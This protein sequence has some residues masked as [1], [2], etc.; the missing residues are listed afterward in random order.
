[1]RLLL[2]IIVFTLSS[3]LIAQV[4]ALIPYQAIA[5]DAAGQPL[6]NGALN[7]RFTIHDGSATGVNVWQEMQT[8]STS[9]LGLFTVQLGSSV[10]L[11]AVNWAD[12]SKFMQVEIDLGSGFVDI[13]T[14]QMLSV[15][16]SLRSE[17]A[18]N[19]YSRVSVNGDSLFFDNGSYVIIPGISRSN[20][21]GYTNGL[22]HTCGTPNVHNPNLN[23]GTM[24]DQEGNTYKTIVIGSQEWM[25]ENLTTSIYRSGDPIPTDLTE[26][27]LVSTTEGAWAYYNNDPSFECPYGKLYNGYTC[28]DP[29]NL[30][31]E[32][33]RVPS[34]SDWQTLVFYLDSDINDGL[35]YSDRA[36]GQMKSTGNIGDGTGLWESPNLAATNISG[37]SGLPGGIGW[38]SGG[39][40]SSGITQAGRFWSA[41]SFNYDAFFIGLDSS[42]NTAGPVYQTWGIRELMSVRCMR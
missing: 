3:S 9:A 2:F 5:R 15:P 24:V 17:S 1:M 36:G 16:Y 29:R 31:P 32:G 40:F 30:C 37:F 10:P 12:G 41:T 20:A 7:A 6:A 14:Q 19:G 38:S 35:N 39:V 8:V 4:P 27:E 21:E 25:A 28:T 42:T 13:G 11:T 18:A 22:P 23:Y 26:A 34:S 33:W